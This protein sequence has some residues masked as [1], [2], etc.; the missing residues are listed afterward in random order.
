MKLLQVEI[1]RLTMIVALAFAFSAC[2]V[3]GGTI[4]GISARNYNDRHAGDW[5]L[6]GEANSQ[7]QSMAS[8]KAR[9]KTRRSVIA[10]MVIGAAVGLVVDVLLLQAALDGA[11]CPGLSADGSEDC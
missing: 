4:G 3:I 10:H 11:Y 1:V 6:K 9:K 7:G 5:M 2:T 8:V